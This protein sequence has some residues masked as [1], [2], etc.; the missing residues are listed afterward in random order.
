MK[1]SQLIK[2]AQKF[3]QCFD[4]NYIKRDKRNG[5]IYCC[6]LGGVSLIL[7]D[8]ETKES[9]FQN[10]GK[11]YS[12]LSDNYE[13]NKNIPYKVIEKTIKKFKDVTGYS[14]LQ[15]IFQ[16]RDFQDIL[17][18][19]DMFNFIMFLN[20]NIRLSFNLISNIIEYI[21]NNIE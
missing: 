4:G 14:D 6:P 3:N 19:L 17:P 12:F 7:A 1:L 5:A 8:T 2:K 11:V 10:Q 15:K 13:Y 21:E 20:D 18:N 16:I 9:F